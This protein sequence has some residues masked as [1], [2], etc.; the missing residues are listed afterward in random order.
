MRHDFLYQER[1]VT[2]L[3]VVFIEISSWGGGGEGDF[4]GGDFP[5]KSTV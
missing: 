1:V 2:T 5:D 3:L 4:N